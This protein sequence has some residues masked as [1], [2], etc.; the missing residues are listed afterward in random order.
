MRNARRDVELVVPELVDWAFVRSIWACCLITSAGA[1]MEHD[2]ASAMAEAA[3]WISGSGRG[4][5]LE[6]V[7]L[8]AS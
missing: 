8:E 4:R 1:R 3:E 7:V 6:R 2:A 5:V